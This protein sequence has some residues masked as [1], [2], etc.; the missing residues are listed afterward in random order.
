MIQFNFIFTFESDI[1]YSVKC[2]RLFLGKD[3]IKSVESVNILGRI[4]NSSNSLTDHMKSRV[5]ISRKSMFSVGINR[6]EFSPKLKGHLWKTIGKQGILFG[7]ESGKMN[8]STMTKLES[9]QG[10]IVKSSLYLGKSHRN[11]HILKALKI[12]SIYDSILERQIKL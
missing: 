1:K 4:F 5:E 12:S 10:S 8:Q 6:P 11:S 3:E 2:P 9:I 7:M